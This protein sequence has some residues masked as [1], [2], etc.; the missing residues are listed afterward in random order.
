[1]RHAI[2][3]KIDCVFKALL[4]AEHNRALLVHFLNAILGAE[5]PAPIVAVDILNPYNEREFVSDKLSIVDVK[6]RDGTGRLYQIEI[7][8]LDFPDLRARIL[9]TWADIYQA[10][11]RRGDNYDRLE[12]VYSIWLLGE[13][14]LPERPGYAHDYRLRDAE[15][16]VLFNHG[17]IWL[18]ELSKFDAPEVETEQQ[19][20]LKFFKDG[21]RLDG[22]ALPEWMQTMEMRQAMSTLKHFSEQERAY[23][24]YQARVTYLRDQ[25]SLQRHL[26]QLRNAVQQEQAA[27]EQER[28]AKEQALAAKEQALAAND[29]ALAEIERLKAQLRESMRRDP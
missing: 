20:W 7:Q 29:E 26:A 24:A 11:L 4:G 15:G 10:Q 18:L 28:A 17:G 6:A 9:Y 21:A 1:M 12:P 22:D 25:R 13:T 8:L 16:H 2:D 23:H 19:R 14:L 27:L 3:P 5:L